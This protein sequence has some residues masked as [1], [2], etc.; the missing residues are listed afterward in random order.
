MARQVAR[1]EPTAT[2][3]TVDEFN[4][5]F[6]ASAAITIQKTAIEKGLNRFWHRD[7]SDVNGHFTPG[8]VARAVA[9]VHSEFNEVLL[10]DEVEVIV[11]IALEAVIYERLMTTSLEIAKGVRNGRS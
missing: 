2:S 10:T 8:E 5:R 11:R 9:E 6:L 7:W 4:Q 3:E 1:E